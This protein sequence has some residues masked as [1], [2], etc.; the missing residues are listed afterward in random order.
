[1]DARVISAFTRV[2]DALLPAHDA[3]ATASVDIALFGIN[4]SFTIALLFRR[5]FARGVIHFASPTPNRGVGGAP[6]VVRVQRH[7]LDVHMTRHARR[8]RGA[9][10]PMTRQYTDRNNI[11]ISTMDGDSVPIVSRR[12]ICPRQIGATYP[13]VGN[14]WG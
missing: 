3:L 8:L 13:R 6:R 14:C 1:M 2:F 7:P 10:R 12:A 5:A 9:L 11:T 4:P